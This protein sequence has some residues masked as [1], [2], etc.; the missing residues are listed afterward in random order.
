M[1]HRSLLCAG[2]VVLL[3]GSAWAQLATQTALVGTVTDS[4]GGVVPGA[5]V[6]AVNIGTQDTY[7][8]T[9]NAQGYYNLQFVRNGSYE[10]TVTMS[11][12]QTF[13]AT[14]VEV[15]TN[16]IVRR[17]AVLQIGAMNELVTVEKSAAVLATDTATISET[18][19][20]KAIAGLPISNGRNVWSLAGTT[21]GVL[22]GTDQFV[23][24]GQRGIQNSLSMDGINAAANLRTQTSMRPIADA[25]TEVDVQTGSTSAEYGSYMGVHINV[26]TKSGTNEP[27]GSLYEFFGSDALDARG[28]FEDRNVPANPQRRDQYGFEIDG[29]IFLP[30]LYDGRNKTFFMS[31]YEKVRQESTGT[32]IVS[33][34]T[35]LMRQG[36]FSEIS[37]NIRDP[38]TGQPFPGKII[39]AGRI[40]SIA[41]KV[42]EFYP[43]PNRPGTGS[44]YLANVPSSAD[45]KQL[46][47]RVDQNLGNKIRL[48]GRYN[49]QDEFSS[50]ASAIPT[51][52]TV[53]PRVNHN[54]LAAYTHTLTTNLFND[55]R[56]GHHDV[57]DDALNYFAQNGLTH[58]GADLGIPGFDG[59]VKYDNPGI[60]NFN[61]SGFNG[62]G[63]SGSNWYQFDRTFQM[64]DVIAYNRG[65]HNIRAGFDV[66]LLETG[67]RAANTPRGLFIFNGDMTGYSVA[68]FMLGLP[69]NV[70]TALE[71]LQGHVG[72][73]RRGFFVNDTWQAGRN[74]TLNLGLRYERHEP[75]GTISGWASMLN[76]DFT[77][78]IPTQLPSPGF[79]FYEPNKK[80]FAPRIGATYRAGEKTVLRAAF[81]IYYNPNQ[82]G[83]FTFLTNNPPLSP[84]Y[85]YDSQPSSP[86]LTLESP[87]GPVGPTA[88][89][90][91]T[92]PNRHLPHARKDQW[93]FDIQREL[94]RTTVVDLQYVGSHTRNLDR[95]F[96]INTPQ[97]GPGPVESRRPMAGFGYLRII[98]NDLIANYDAVSVIL[99][100]RLN[101]GLQ[102]TAHYTWSRTRDMA[103]NGN[104]SQ[105]TMMNPFDIWAD[106]GPA[107]WDVPHRFVGDFVYALPFFQ[108]SQQ[109]IL[110]YVVA[111]WQLS[112]I[113]TLQSG[114]PMSVMI[115]GDRANTGRLGQRP[116][117]VGTPTADCGSGRLTN[118]IDATAFALPAMFTYGNAPRNVL[119]GP[120]LA[121][122][123]L[124][125]LKNFPLA[126]NAQ[127]Q[128]RADI[129]NVF[130]RPN[131][132]NPNVTFGTA[133]FGRITSAQRMR[134]IVL[135]GKLFF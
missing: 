104:I 29:P 81:G 71:Q 34:P 106:Y 3:A 119:R 100:H 113:T 38:F 59:D 114:R 2:L 110:K 60:P 12:F 122:T 8:A 115:Q 83:S 92:S 47:L 54:W 17:D 95:S 74:L 36:N 24:A 44:N 124:S 98:Q 55:F 50:S 61:L 5:T 131:F 99:R 22:S 25:V 58:A 77:G 35:A 42:M 96:F 132:N 75:T 20:E 43:M 112:G 28:F 64:S 85:V 123:D 26:V 56:I 9:T 90:N 7:E 130:N 15:T 127:F 66:R 19:G 91:I 86:T 69:R 93:S 37:A 80:D 116:D 16:Q 10:I 120:G 82:M 101:R 108:E 48:Y 53:V 30:K 70:T 111:G 129:S 121:I 73:W 135:G 103:D 79:A 65:S 97:P 32:S 18:I 6:V 88:Y 41:Q 46:L 67:R 84:V 117:L 52:G 62:L 128:F 76:A 118:C 21:P 107:D 87:T 63:V 45:S 27:H 126:G 14:G 134:Q 68:D 94:W 102:A 133:N 57:D 51:S 13:K 105:D 89:P 72:G 11:G 31:A 23:G 1:V 109:P 4:T 125:L 49:W 33:V 40:S 78:L 39:P